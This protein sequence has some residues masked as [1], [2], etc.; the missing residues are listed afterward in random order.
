VV[1]SCHALTA[2]PSA[3]DVFLK[4]ICLMIK[5]S[6]LHARRVGES[7]VIKC[8]PTCHNSAPATFVAMY[9]GEGRLNLK[10]GKGI[11]SW[12]DGCTY[13]GI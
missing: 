12:S 8:G 1:N 10:H 6:Y 3:M 2:V 5:T 11:Y 9:E 13:D 4:R 7:H